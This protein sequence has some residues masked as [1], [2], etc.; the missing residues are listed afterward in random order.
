MTPGRAS[1][2]ASATCAGVAPWRAAISRSTAGA[3]APTSAP[4]SSGLWASSGIAR[5]RIHGSR[6]NS[7]PRCEAE[8]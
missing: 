4:S 2:A 7:T 6:S 8:W 3:R 1:S 5:A